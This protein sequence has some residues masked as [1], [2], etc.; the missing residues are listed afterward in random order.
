M[1]TTMSFLI[2]PLLPARGSELPNLLW[3]TCEDIGPH[4][5][6]YGDAY[7]KTPNLDRLAAQGVRYTNAFAI[8]GVCAPNR[9]C[10]ITGLYP[11]T[12]GSHHMRC[13]TRLPDFVRCFPSYLRAAG[14]YCTNNVKTD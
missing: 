5:G 10:L 4:L 13:N 2:L 1:G 6:C 3:I 14:Y 12:L 7:A 9:S 11:S 8:A